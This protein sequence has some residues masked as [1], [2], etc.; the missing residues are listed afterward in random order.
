M[1]GPDL[2][3]GGDFTDIGWYG[4]IDYIAHWTGSWWP[5]DS[6]LNGPARTIAV[7]GSDIYVGGEFTDA[8]GHPDAD[9]IA[10]W[11]ATYTP[12]STVYLPLALK[13]SP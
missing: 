5:L 2:Y 1:A 3:V 9:N 12:Y 8:G 7:A 11:G 13:D 6:G 4:D 10:R